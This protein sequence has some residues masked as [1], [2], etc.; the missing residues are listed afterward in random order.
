MNKVIKR[1]IDK[2]FDYIGE[3]TSF[4]EIDRNQGLVKIRNKTIAWYLAYEFK[5]EDQYEKW[6]SWATIELEKENMGNKL[7][8]IIL[9][10]SLN[11]PLK[12]LEKG[13]QIKMF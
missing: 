13:K 1:I 9:M 5:D 11:F 6:L 3:K 8:E 2:Q 12:Q 7:L 10:Y 4:E